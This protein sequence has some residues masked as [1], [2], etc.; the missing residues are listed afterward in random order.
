MERYLMSLAVRTTGTSWSIP[1]SRW[2]LWL[3]Y[4]FGLGLGSRVVLDD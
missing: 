3:G 1:E 2:L 4:T